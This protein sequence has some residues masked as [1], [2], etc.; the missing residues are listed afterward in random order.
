MLQFGVICLTGIA[1]RVP[2]HE[3]PRTCFAT[4]AAAV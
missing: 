4:G 2:G 3:I 1:S